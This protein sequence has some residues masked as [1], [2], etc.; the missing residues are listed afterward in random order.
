MK[1]G[2]EVLAAVVLLAILLTGW[3]GMGVTQE[4][5]VTQDSVPY[6]ILRSGTYL[7]AGDLNGDGWPY[8]VS[9]VS[10][11]VTFNGRY[12]SIT[13][14][15]GGK[16][17]KSVGL[18]KGVK[19]INTDLDSG[20]CYGSSLFLSSLINVEIY[21]NRVNLAN[22]MNLDGGSIVNNQLCSR[23]G[24]Y[25]IDISSSRNVTVSGN[26]A[27]DWTWIQMFG[28]QS[29]SYDSNHVNLWLDGCDRIWGA[30]NVFEEFKQFNCTNV[31]I[32]GASAV[33]PETNAGFPTAFALSQNYPNPFNPTTTIRYQ[34]PEASDVTLTLYN[35]SGQEIATLVQGRQDAGYYSVV[36]NTEGMASGIYF[37]QLDAGKFTATK[38]MVVVK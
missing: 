8:A 25:A 22:F 27:I 38:K 15:D 24:S 18:W 4:V 7:A 28:S 5:F 17:I 14:G 3:S 37:Y 10:D 11:S 21:N 26:K 6:I 35:A 29:V 31:N 2:L 13:W 32:Q 33:D 16:A 19:I 1:K 36:W 23:D 30:G 9:I 12:Y 20:S 34:L